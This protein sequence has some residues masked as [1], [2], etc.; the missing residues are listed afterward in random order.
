MLA[1]VESTQAQGLDTLSMAIPTQKV[2]FDSLKQKWLTLGQNIS[3]KPSEW[4]LDTANVIVVTNI[5]GAKNGSTQYIYSLT[6]KVD[7]S[8]I[9]L[10]LTAA[11][12]T[13]V[14]ED[15]TKE[16]C[17]CKPIKFSAWDGKGWEA[18]NEEIRKS[19]SDF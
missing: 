4:T 2:Q 3:I 14:Q 11:D 16:S 9:L 8:K 10:F 18:D 7:P 6:N 17:D 13:K 19:A 15:F 1:A 12:Q 5:P